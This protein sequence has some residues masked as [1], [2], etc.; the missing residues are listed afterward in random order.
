VNT[1]GVF[2][3]NKFP[4]SLRKTRYCRNT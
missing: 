4:T 2:I 1:V 3:T